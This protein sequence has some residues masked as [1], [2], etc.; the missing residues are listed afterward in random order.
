MENHTTSKI[1][2][3][4]EAKMPFKLDVIILM[5]NLQFRSNHVTIII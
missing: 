1:I 4:S 5:V 2:T 3:D